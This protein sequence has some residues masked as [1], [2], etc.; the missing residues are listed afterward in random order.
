MKDRNSIQYLL[1]QNKQ[2]ELIEFI[3]SNCKDLENKYKD[4]VLPKYRT[5]TKICDNLTLCGSNI[6]DITDCINT[7]IEYLKCFYIDDKLN[8]L[9]NEMQEFKKNYSDNQQ[10]IITINSFTKKKIEKQIIYKE[11]EEFIYDYSQIKSSKQ[12]LHKELKNI[13]KIFKKIIQ[14]KYIPEAILVVSAK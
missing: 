13:Y 1:Y 5:I 9:N 2:N 10:N 3:I 14:N 6:D 12:D 8:S 11:T 4:K 7:S